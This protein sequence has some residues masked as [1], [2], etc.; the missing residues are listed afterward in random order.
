MAQHDDVL[1]VAS[2]TPVGDLA[3]AVAHGVYDGR[4]V[5][6]RYVGAAAGQQAIKAVAV[7][8]GMVAPR[9]ID[10]LLLPG[11]CDIEMPEGKIVT[12]ITLKIIVR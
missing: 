7:A 5:V 6:L 11:F 9:G 10:L 3:S 2:G 1:R 4:E 12:G 8:R